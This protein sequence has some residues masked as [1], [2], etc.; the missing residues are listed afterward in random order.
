MYNAI[1]TE[2]SPSTRQKTGAPAVSL[3]CA[4]QNELLRALPR[5]ELERLFPALE[6]VRLGAG[7]RL[8]DFGAQLD[9]AYFPTNAII[10]L[11]YI[12]EDGAI[13]ETAVVGREGVTGVAIYRGELAGNTAV[14]TGAGYGYRLPVEALRSTFAEGGELARQLMRYTSAMF[15]QLAQNVVSSRHSSIDQKLCRWLLERL[16]R[17][18]GQQLKVTQE[19]IASLLGVR[20]ESITAAAAKLQAD[21]AIECRRGVIDVIDRTL[22]EAGAGAC[23]FA[24]RLA[25]VM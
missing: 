20:R 15:T 25:C 7:K 17:T 21:G 23:Y 4:Q 24:P 19:A 8:Y 3:A 1:T 14:V 12:N 16:D 22:L 13:T 9:Y 11:Q 2:S 5:A 6:L 18:L 10:S